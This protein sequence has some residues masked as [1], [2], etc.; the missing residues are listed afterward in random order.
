MPFTIS[1]AAAV[2][3]FVRR[4]GAG[5]GPFVPALL[6]AGSCAPDLTYYAAGAVPGAMEFGA[7]THSF[8]GVCTVD[9]V[10]AVTLVGV[11]RLVRDP[12]LGLT[13][14]RLRGRLAAVLGPRARTGWWPVWWYASAVLG[15]TTHIVWDAFTHPD[16]WG[17]RLFPILDEPFAGSP[18]YWYAQY[19][20]S[21][22]ALAVLA[23]FAWRTLRSATPVPA[24][25]G[26]P[27]W[28]GC[29]LITS[30]ACLAATL[31]VTRWLSYVNEADLP[32]QPWEIIPALCFG[33]GAG[34][35]VGVV[36]YALV[37]RARKASPTKPADTSSPVT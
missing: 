23:W 6:V 31:R 14:E 35:A 16:R 29:L 19:A 15:A 27:R 17:V 2:L 4:D 21:A 30:C 5:R 22:V 25:V 20:G 12:L 3:P 28:L 8:A 33:A 36:L 9:V 1:H 10:L 11:W 24:P 32:W 26:G 7:F 34:A 18:L 37:S 13:P